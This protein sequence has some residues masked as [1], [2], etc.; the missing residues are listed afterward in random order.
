MM[1]ESTVRK[2]KR[3][4]K[5]KVSCIILIRG[6][7]NFFFFFLDVYYS[8][9]ID[10]HCSKSAKYYNFTSTATWLFWNIGGAKIAL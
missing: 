7:I 1:R 9:H 4:E 10:V 6:C 5:N 8:A 2:N 3:N